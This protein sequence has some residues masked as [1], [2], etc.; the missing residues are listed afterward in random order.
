M[1]HTRAIDGNLLSSKHDKSRILFLDMY[2]KSMMEACQQW[3]DGGHIHQ[4]HVAYCYVKDTLAK[5]LDLCTERAQ[6]ILVLYLFL[7]SP[8]H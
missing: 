8:L 1:R 6:H 2:L 5:G 3:L 4:D 7:L